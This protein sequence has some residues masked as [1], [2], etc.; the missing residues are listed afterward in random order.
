[1]NPSARQGLLSQIHQMGGE[2]SSTYGSFS[3]LPVHFL[4]QPFAPEDLIPIYAVADVCLCTPLR[5]YF[6]SLTNKIRT[7]LVT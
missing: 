3:H 4:D 1:M 5:C 6:F 7:S 2:I